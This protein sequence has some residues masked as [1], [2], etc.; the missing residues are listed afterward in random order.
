[1]VP[2]KSKKPRTSTPLL[3]PAGPTSQPTAAPIAIAARIGV[4]AMGRD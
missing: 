4:A 2:R 3:C 1:M